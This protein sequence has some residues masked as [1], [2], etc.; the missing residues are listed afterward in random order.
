MKT[1]K[2]DRVLEE[3]ATLL[4][5]HYPTLHLVYQNGRNLIQGSFP[6]QI[7]GIIVS[8]YLIEIELPRGYPKTPPSIKEIGSRV[9][10]DI[11]RHVFN[12][13]NL[14]LFLPEE[15]AK[16]WPVGSTIIDYL[17]GPVN[18][19]F[20]SQLHFEKTGKWPFG[21]RRHGIL[22]IM[23]YYSEELDTTDPEIILRCL[24]YLR[25]KQPKGH[26]YCYCGSGK[27]LRDCHFDKLKELHNKIDP[28][29]AENSFQI[30]IIA[31]ERCAKGDNL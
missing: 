28:S 7:N 12:S 15:R 16:Y 30:C 17:D 23:D 2:R 1:T 14:C 22:G 3:V 29:V 20:I 11:D 9:P 13:D 18:D 10:R 31:L 27:R 21:E 25:K 6:V 26:W 24:D 5:D 19:F 4:H 8:H